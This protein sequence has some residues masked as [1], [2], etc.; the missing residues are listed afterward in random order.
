SAGT[1]AASAPVFFGKAA[2]GSTVASV[3]F[4]GSG[5][6]AFFEGKSGTKITC[7]TTVSF[8]GEVT[9]AT[10][11]ANVQLTPGGC[12]L[13]DA[14]RHARK[15][16]VHDAGDPLLQPEHRSRGCTAG[17]HL[18]RGCCEIHPSWLGDRIA[19][20]SVGHIGG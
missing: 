15:C 17:I 18:R 2:V 16:H 4:T 5:E 9:G 13:P 3:P 6:S 10:E 11:V 14:R 19:H 7:T 12:H 20:R 1:A 8:S